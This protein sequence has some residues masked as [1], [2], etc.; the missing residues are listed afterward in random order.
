MVWTVFPLSF[1]F[2]FSLHL[3]LPRHLTLP[4]GPISSRF[5]RRALSSKRKTQ[6]FS[7][8]TKGPCQ[9]SRSQP[10]ALPA[11]NWQPQEEVPAGRAGLA[12]ARQHLGRGWRPNGREGCGG[13]A[14]APSRPPPVGDSTPGTCGQRCAAWG[15]AREA[16]PPSRPGLLRPAAPAECAD[17][18]ASSRRGPGSTS[19]P[20]F[21][22]G[23]AR[24]RPRVPGWPAGSRRPAPS[25][26]LAP[27]REPPAHP[28]PLSTTR[29]QHGAL[30]GPRV[31]APVRGGHRGGG[32]GSER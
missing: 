5:Q 10:T 27:S 22:R 29:A 18:S 19:P 11:P 6:F 15:R 32:R 16:G 23:P 25:A 9:L 2:H 12:A 17:T 26:C 30:P 31:R 3:P 21:R 7:V 1:V 13:G 28:A 8:A 24:P 14:L 4:S 20:S